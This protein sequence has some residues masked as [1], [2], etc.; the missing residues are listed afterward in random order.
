LRAD[1]IQTFDNLPSA[2]GEKAIR[3]RQVS[4]FD[5]LLVSVAR[6]VRQAVMGLGEERIPVGSFLVKSQDVTSSA[7]PD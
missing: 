7:R 5:K 2:G 4:T 6:D 3:R 1:Q